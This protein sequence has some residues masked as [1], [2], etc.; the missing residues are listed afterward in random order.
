MTKG[1]ASKNGWR[2]LRIPPNIGDF[3]ILNIEGHP[4]AQSQKFIWGPKYQNREYEMQNLGT[5]KFGP[6][7][8][9]NFALVN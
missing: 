4:N 3:V 7:H 2:L 6:I 9:L 8:S 1:E 5:R